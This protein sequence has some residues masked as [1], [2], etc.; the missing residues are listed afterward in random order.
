[1]TTHFK[2]A[3][4]NEEMP[5]NMKC[6][7]GTGF[8]GDEKFHRRKD[9]YQVFVSEGPED[10]DWDNFLEKT[11]GGHHV[12]SSSWGRLKAQSGYL[13]VRLVAKKE[14]RIV[15]GAQV[16]IRRI[17]YLGS[18]AYVS[19]GP[20]FS[21]DDP[22]LV[23]LFMNKLLT[24]CKGKKSRYIA[25]QPPSNGESIALQL[26][27]WGFSKSTINLAPSAT[28]LINLLPDLDVILAQM[29][30][31]AR[32]NIRYG[33]RKGITVREGSE[34]D[35]SAFYHL[36]KSTSVR[37]KFQIYP[38]RYYFEMWR[39]LAPRGNL[40]L[41]LAEYGGDVVSAQL[42]VPFR[43]TMI[44]K[45]SVWSGRHG[46]LRPNEVLQ[47]NAIT[48]AKSHGYR[49]FDFEGI[50]TDTA[51]ALLSKKITVDS[52]KHS[53]TSFKLKFGGEVTLFPSS[54]DY[55]YN[56]S[57]RWVYKNLFPRFKNSRLLRTVVN[58]NRSR[59]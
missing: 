49:Y 50:D 38:E 27:R 33:L 21:T 40:K 28:V 3:L 24:F 4:E 39:A 1:M 6:N 51:K 59:S 34:N 53:V 11:P 22:I 13:S 57:L 48:W 31:E 2:I 17:P 36:L 41:F 14:E 58:Y 12:Q 54:Y 42:A 45:M 55:V 7:G 30:R 29:D 52:I 18:I 56:P 16:L 5:G 10:S 25:I 26:P 46:N 8:P 9:I 43:D 32:R 47:W 44:N 15:A 23:N 35:L 37:Q 20:L 19:R